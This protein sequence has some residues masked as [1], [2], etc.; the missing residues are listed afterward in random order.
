MSYYSLKY[1]VFFLLFS[2]SFLACDIF[3][4]NLEDQSNQSIPNYTLPASPDSL[5]L[6]MQTSFYQEDDD[7]FVT[8]IED[9]R[10]SL[11]LLRLTQ[12]YTD[13]RWEIESTVLNSWRGNGLK[14]FLQVDNKSVIVFKEGVN[15]V[16]SV[17]Q[18][19]DTELYKFDQFESY[20]DTAYNDVDSVNL[21]CLSLS[22]DSLSYIVGGALYSFGQQYSF[23]MELNEGLTPLWVQTYFQSAS[24]SGVKSTTGDTLI[25]IHNSEEGSDLIIDN[26]GGSIYHRV[27]VS[28]L[29]PDDIFFASEVGELDEDLLIAGINNNIGRLILINLQDLNSYVVESQVYP[30]SDISLLRLTRNSWIMSGVQKEAMDNYFITEMGVQGRR[31][32]HQ[33]N[34]ENYIK[35]FGLVENQ[36]KG[37]NGL[38]MIERNG[39]FY[40]QLTRID[41]EGATFIDEFTESCI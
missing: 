22:N 25:M 8:C 24:I 6:E 14:G 32:C 16:I 9:I 37:I 5:R 18:D 7:N 27:S 29:S 20:L 19:Y 26:K 4:S 40:L 33:Y 13:D 28:D 1:Y 12:K 30:V 36:G 35:S 2:V 21:E 10:G 39:I 11:K 41:E 3:R 17:I 38:A 31:W 23:V 15:S 34:D